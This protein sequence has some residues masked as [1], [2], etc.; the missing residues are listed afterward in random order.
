MNSSG[1]KNDNKNMYDARRENSILNGRWLLEDPFKVIESSK[2]ALMCSCRHRKYNNLLKINRLHSF[3]VKNILL[4]AFLYHFFLSFH[5]SIRVLNKDPVY[6]EG[7]TLTESREEEEAKLN[8]GFQKFGHDTSIRWDFDAGTE[9]W[10]NATAEE[11]DIETYW[12]GGELRGAIRGEHP[13]LDSPP[14]VLSVDSSKKENFVFRMR[15]S[16]ISTSGRLLVRQGLQGMSSSMPSSSKN[17]KNADQQQ[18]TIR[19]NVDAS[20]V[21]WSKRPNTTTLYTSADL[22]DVGVNGE[23]MSENYYMNSKYNRSV[24]QEATDRNQYTYWSSGSGVKKDAWLVLDSHRSVTVD[25]IEIDITRDSNAPRNMRLQTSSRP[26][27]YADQDSRTSFESGTGRRVDNSVS[28]WKT[29]AT[30]SINEHHF[31][32]DDSSSP[33]TYNFTMP[34]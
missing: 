19:W 10:G 9:G 13:H 22:A 33:Y 1:E 34:T 3:R 28:G 32:I 2:S 4:L 18:Q 8:T 5:S 24:N 15:Y 17:K 30:F 20:Q 16:G 12:R 21:Q 14:I 23:H 27:P 31:P 29:V 26:D 6:V 25:H 7:T 11:L